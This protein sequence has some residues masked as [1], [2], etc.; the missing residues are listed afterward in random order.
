MDLFRIFNLHFGH[1]YGY[2]R[3]IVDN[4]VIVFVAIN[5]SVEKWMNYSGV[6][7]VWGVIQAQD[8]DRMMMAFV[9]NR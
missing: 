5:I 3:S 9:C 4:L 8:L 7:W 2:R 6:S 1:S